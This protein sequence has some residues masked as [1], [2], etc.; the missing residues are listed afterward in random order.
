MPRTRMVLLALA[1]AVGCS[2]SDEPPEAA[3]VETGSVAFLHGVAS[4]DPGA[5]RAIIWTRVTPVD[6]LALAQVDV[7]WSMATDQT[8]QNVVARGQVSTSTT[9]DFTVKVDVTGLAP[10]TTYFYRFAASGARSPVGRTKTLPVGDASSVKFAVVSCSN[11][12]AGFFNVYRLIADRTDGADDL[13]AV[14]HLGDYFYEYGPGGFGDAAIASRMPDPANETITLEDYRRRH[15]QYKTDAD[16]QA[17]HAVHPMIAVWDDHESANDAWLG[18]AQNHDATE[19][20]WNARRSAAIQA[21][22]EWMPVR[23]PAM[24]GAIFRQFQFG[25]LVTLTMLDTRMAGRSRQLDYAT[26]DENDPSPF[27]AALLDARRSMLGTAQELWLGAQLAGPRNTVWDLIGQQVMVA[28]LYVPRLQVPIADPLIEQFNDIARFGDALVAQG[29]LEGLGLGLN[30]DAWDGYIPAR[31][32]LFTLLDPLPN[33]VVVT[34]DFHSAWASDLVPESILGAGWA[35]GDAGPVGVEFVTSSVTSPGLET[36]VPDVLLSGLFQLIKTRNPHIRYADLRRRGYLVVE[37]TPTN[38]FGQ[39]YFTDRVDAPSTI[40]QA[41]PRYR[42][43][44]GR[45]GL[46]DPQ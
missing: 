17:M 8:M 10:G 46:V 7:A 5:D 20:S 41:G 38:A 44:A 33:V 39:F 24:G 14:I 1:S 32:R 31:S 36:Q 3:I 34:G 25:N 11:Y 45:K 42:V 12:P 4:G 22:Y 29:T 28:P 27:I 2:G 15:A 35:P 16:L 37:F 40:E 13:D 9:V 21:Y 6:P 26:L 23:E 19:G 30:L 43:M 18:G